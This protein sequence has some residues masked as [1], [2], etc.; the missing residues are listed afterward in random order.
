[1]L[2]ELIKKATGGLDGIVDDLIKAA[3]NKLKEKVSQAFS[4]RRLAALKENIE[5]IGKVKTILNPD[6]IVDLD[7]IY[8]SEAIS[9]ENSG[10][11]ERV[12][13]FPSKQILIEGGPGQ[14]KSLY[15]KHLCINEGKN[16]NFIPIFIEFRYLSFEKPLREELFDAIRSFGV[17]LD[18][19]LFDYLAKSTKLLFILDGFDEVPNKAR[20]KTARALEDI[21]RTY[22]NL[23]M[24]VSSRPGA[25]MGASVYFMK[26]TIA[27]LPYLVQLRFIHHLHEDKSLADDIVGVLESSTFISKVTNTPLLLTLFSITYSARQFKPD[28]ISEFYSLIFPTM[29]Y[30]HD[31]MKL[32]YERERK[33]GLTD[34]QMQRLFEALSFISL[35][36]NKT[37]LSS[38][39]FRRFLESASKIERVPSG[40]EDTLIDDIVTITAL[41]VPDGFDFFSYA[42]KSIQEYFSSVFISRIGESHKVSFYKSLVQSFDEF[43]KWQNVLSFLETIDRYHYLKHYLLP[44]R[45]SIIGLSK[46]KKVNLTLKE[47]QTLVG[48]DSK[49]KIDETGIVIKAYWGDTYSSSIYKDYSEYTQSAVLSFLS[50]KASDLADFLSFCDVKDFEVYKHEDNSFIINIMD[51]VNKKALSKTLLSYVCR[52]FEGSNLIKE[53]IKVE[54]E[55]IRSEKIVSNIMDFEK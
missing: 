16:S 30:R 15:L 12:D 7:K 44:V 10:C 54:E 2:D 45:K 20:A 38:S 4:I 23:R 47:M 19:S 14:G 1:M 42:H 32:G 27:R 40:L 52:S 43:R 5:R 8:F 49:I 6:T 3:S 24:I 36:A 13:F 55:L 34:Y 29:L 48:L 37:R 11:I 51:F 26:Y 18:D 46:N 50:S 35:K 31:R 28:S 22:P 9:F 41:V 33:A 21:G 17:D 25:G 53:I 39:E